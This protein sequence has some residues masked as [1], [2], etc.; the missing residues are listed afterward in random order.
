MAKDSEELRQDRSAD[1]SALGSMM[2]D[3]LRNGGLIS[4][5]DWAGNL[6][7]LAAEQPSESKPLAKVLPFNGAIKG[8]HFHRPAPT[9]KPQQKL[10][11]K[12]IQGVRKADPAPT[13]PATETVADWCERV[14]ASAPSAVVIDI[15][16]ELRRIREDARR[17]LANLNA[18]AERRYA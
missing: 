4:Q 10:V 5:L 14:A 1:R 2:D 7:G 16:P 6:T 13:V 3:Y 15:V 18:A 12:P 8:D 9:G 17:A 11:V